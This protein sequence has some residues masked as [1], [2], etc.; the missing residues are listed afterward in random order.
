[1]SDASLKQAQQAT[2]KRAQ[3]LIDWKN[4]LVDDINR[5]HFSGA[6]SDSSGAKYTGIAGAT[7]QSLSLKLP[8]GIA[9]VTW[10][11]LSPETL[12]T[13]STSFVKPNAPDAPDRQWRCAVFASEFGQTEVARQWAEAAAKVNSRYH[14]QVSQLFA[15]PPQFR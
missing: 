6:I 8:Y 13:V 1:L 5:A 15:S 10:R 4:N 12:L 3:W 7:D 9:R 2:E 14:E 11:E